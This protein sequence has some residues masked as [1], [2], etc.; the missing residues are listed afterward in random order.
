MR[1]PEV[2]TAA[3]SLLEL[4]QK[5]EDDLLRNIASKLKVDEI[6]GDLDLNEWLMD[7]M[8]QVGQLNKENAKTIAKYAKRTPKEIEKA[9]QDAGY[10]ILKYDE[11]IYREAFGAG[12]LAY[13]PE[14]IHQSESIK[15]ILRTAIPHA[16]N[17][18]NLVNTT[19]HESA[20]QAFTD[21]VNQSYLETVTGVYSHQEAVKK[22]VTELGD[23]GI[24]GAHYTSA[25]GRET[26]NYIDVAVRRAVL[27]SASQVANEM[28]LARASDWGSDLVEVSSHMG[29]RPAHAEWQGRIY[30]LS[31][32]HP[33]YKDF[34]LSTQY[35]S[36]TGLGGANCNH[37]FY[38]FF[39]GISERTYHPYDQ[40]EN[41][42]AYEQ[43]QQQRKIER[44]IRKEKRKIV[45]A[46]AAN[47]HQGV[48][49]H[50]K[51]LQSKQAEMR[52]FIRDTDRERRRD[53]E[54][55]VGY[56]IGEV[57]RAK[58]ALEKYPRITQH[59]STIEIT[60][61]I[62]EGVY[63]KD[64]HIG[65]HNKHIPG[66]NEYVTNAEARTRRG[67]GP[68]NELTISPEEAQ[69]IINRYS[70]KGIV[71]ST[72]DGKPR[73]VEYISTNKTLGKYYKNGVPHETKKATVHYSKDGAHL[74]P[75][76]G[77]GYD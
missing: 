62:E 41:K 25:A 35:G 69:R 26:W 60:R 13:M 58:E 21:A 43:S 20:I 14:A 42:V 54:Q 18:M 10:G 48:L 59:S 46:E 52:Q 37:H 47:D 5:M 68:A 22:A 45:T 19:A 57:G 66:T 76:E 33:K 56:T 50:N 1:I 72:R 63:S 29:A 71:Q 24:K 77:K 53:R 9:L 4:Y 49:A 8:L 11:T 3:S 16:Q 67:W 32:K 51:R 28:Q 15:Q 65:R 73:N 44:D 36:V 31:G 6:T 17:K 27:T 55:L 40:E 30:S 12:K 2:E 7:R 74:V 23:K 34:Y 39:E 61:K 64:L 70:G 75:D 38:P